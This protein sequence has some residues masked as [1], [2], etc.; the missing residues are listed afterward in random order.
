M[1]QYITLMC[2]LLLYT[3]RQ[4]CMLV[5]VVLYV[6]MMLPLLLGV[7]P[8]H[9]VSYLKILTLPLTFVGKVSTARAGL[10]R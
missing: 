8:G 4:K 7:V 6:L 10:V 9:I 3:G 2:L 1:A 5:F